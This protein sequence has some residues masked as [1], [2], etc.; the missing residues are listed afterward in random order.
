M[1][2]QGY[3]RCLKGSVGEGHGRGKYQIIQ[4]YFVSMDL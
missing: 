3:A 4:S 1:H 2:V